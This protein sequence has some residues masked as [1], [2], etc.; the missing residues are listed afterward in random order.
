VNAVSQRDSAVCQTNTQY[1][2]DFN[3]LL[4]VIPCMLLCN[5]HSLFTSTPRSFLLPLPQCH[6]IFEKVCLIETRM[7]TSVYSCIF[8]IMRGGNGSGEWGSACVRV[9]L[10]LSLA[11]KY[12]ISAGTSCY[13]PYSRNRNGS[14]LKTRPQTNQLTE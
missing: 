5:T 14:P 6:C 1:P 13:S 7:T 11:L 8:N 4:G 10:R 3:M 12:D 2:A 9:N